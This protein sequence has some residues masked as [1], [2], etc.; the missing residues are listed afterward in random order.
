MYR[1]ANV[2]IN[3]KVKL[4]DAVRECSRNSIAS[5][6]NIV[7]S[8]PGNNTFLLTDYQRGRLSVNGTAMISCYY[9]QITQ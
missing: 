8:E 4:Y 1:H 9:D 7:V 5:G 3:D 2:L 6:F